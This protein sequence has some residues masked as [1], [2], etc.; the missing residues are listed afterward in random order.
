MTHPNKRRGNNWEREIVNC[1][2]EM[3]LDAKRAY[4][5]DGRSLGQEADVDLLVSGKKVQAKV[6]ARIPSYLKVPDSCDATA[7]KETRGQ[8]WVLLRLEDWLEMVKSTN[9][10]ARE[11]G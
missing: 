2:Q 5:S 11:D 6:R 1:A 7:F 3:G 9:K 10:E 8:R 4:G